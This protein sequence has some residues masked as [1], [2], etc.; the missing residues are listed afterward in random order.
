MNC[1]Q[2]E[3]KIRGDLRQL[4]LKATPARL[5]LLDLLVHAE[6]PLSPSEVASSL[7]GGVDASTVYRNLEALCVLGLIQKVSLRARQ[8]Y[9]EL[10][11]DF[12]GRPHRHHLVCLAC[13]RVANI[14]DCGVTVPAPAS[15]KKAGFATISDHSLEFF[16][17]CQACQPVGNK[18]FK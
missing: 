1:Q 11:D 13:A 6:R 4:K 15:L 2:H 7:G 8:A 18:K 14:Y 17:L 9:Y 12:S 10:A 3:Q 16:G 5:H